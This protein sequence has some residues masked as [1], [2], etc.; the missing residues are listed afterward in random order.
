MV[1]DGGKREKR[2][3][4]GRGGKRRLEDR[5]PGLGLDRLGRS[6]CRRAEAEAASDVRREMPEGALMPE[7]SDDSTR[8]RTGIP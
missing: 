2:K 1:G 6:R 8:L 4:E 5:S 3:R 7:G